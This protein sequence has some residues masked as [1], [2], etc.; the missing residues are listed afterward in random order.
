[1]KRAPCAPSITRWSYDSD[2]GS[3]SRGANCLPSHTGFMT[4]LPTPRI[5]TSGALMI[6]VKKRAA[7]TAE[8]GDREAAALHV[9]GIDLAVAHARADC[10]ELFREFEQA[11]LVGVANHRHDQA[12]RRVDR[13]A[14]VEVLLEDQVLA[15]RRTATH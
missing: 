11:L 14:D 8:A 10:A 4:D 7:D 5:A 3:I 13:D 12:D 6:G 1:M 2:S 9:G 15:V